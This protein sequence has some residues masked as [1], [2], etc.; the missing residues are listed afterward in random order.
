MKTDTQDQMNNAIELI[1]RYLPLSKWNFKESIR[2]FD[3]KIFP[4][5]IYDS[6]K[7]RIR[8]YLDVQAR[9]GNHNLVIHYGTLEVPDNAKV[10]LVADQSDYHQLW[11]SIFSALPFL[12]GLSP[13]EAITEKHPRF[14]REFEESEIA[15]KISY[16]PEKTLVKHAAIWDTYGLKFFELFDNRLTSQWEKY[17]AFIRESG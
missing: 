3:N 1:E 11:H 14:I 15:K 12:D 7:C 8:I 9:H 13:Q 2:F 17:S 10:L 4:T 16:E 5:I 6:E